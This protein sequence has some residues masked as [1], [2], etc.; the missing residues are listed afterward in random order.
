[1][2]EVSEYYINKHLT[3]PYLEALYHALFVTGYF[4]L[5]RIG[6]L[7]SGSHPI[8][9]KDVQIA[10][11]KKKMQ[12]TLHSSKTHG[13][14]N[15]PQVVKISSLKQSANL[16]EC[17]VARIN[18]SSADFCPYQIICRYAQVRG[19]FKH[20]S[21]PFFIFADGSPVRPHHMT[22]CLKLVLARLGK[23]A[24][25]FSVHSL[26]IGRSTDLLELGLSVETIKSWVDG[27]LM[28]SSDTLDECH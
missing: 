19:P 13:V 3:Q 22:K 20:D 15:L 14:G 9:A 10:T 28:R 4:G 26:R 1:M 18:S 17:S 11:N 6:K 2:D 25:N 7:T 8:L 27:N 16:G 24:R 21:D 5:F 23:D 12:F